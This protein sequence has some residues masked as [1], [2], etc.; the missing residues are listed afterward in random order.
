MFAIRWFKII[1]GISVIQNQRDSLMLKRCQLTWKVVLRLPLQ[2][3]KHILF[4]ILAYKRNSKTDNKQKGKNEGVLI[5][6]VGYIKSSIDRIE[7]NMDKLEDRYNQLSN[8]LTKTEESVAQAHKRITEHINDKTKHK[9]GS[10]REWYFIKYYQCGGNC[11]Y[12]TT[13]YYA[14]E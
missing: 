1:M 12:N 8:Q 11:N 2:M 6:D 4:A 14:R 13:N 5:S 7:K 9:G 10:N 3:I